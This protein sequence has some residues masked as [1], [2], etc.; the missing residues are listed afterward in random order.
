M[1]AYDSQKMPKRSSWE[2]CKRSGRSPVPWMHGEDSKLW[3][4]KHF[5][6]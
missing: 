2:S 1:H 3:D 6:I 5:R 4:Q